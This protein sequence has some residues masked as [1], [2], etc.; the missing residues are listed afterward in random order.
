MRRTLTA[1]LAAL[2]AGALLA[3]CGSGGS[4]EK[5]SLDANG[6][7]T[8][9]AADFAAWQ[10]AAAA[11]PGLKCQHARMVFPDTGEAVAK[12]DDAKKIKSR[13]TP[14]FQCVKLPRSAWVFQAKDAQIAKANSDAA[15]VA[16]NA[17]GVKV[18]KPPKG[19]PPGTSCLAYTDQ[20]RW[21]CYASWNNLAMMSDSLTSLAEAGELISG[22]N[23]TIQ[24]LFS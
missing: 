11:A 19:T 8:I 3:G 7:A 22:T 9:R 12:P 23:A 16:K 1:L 13:Q 10:Q 2:A 4:G 5:P 20:K 6:N 15:T 14:S 21:T 18:V 17:Q 24:Q